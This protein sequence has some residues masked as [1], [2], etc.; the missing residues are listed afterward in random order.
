ML[1]LDDDSVRLVRDSRGA[2][3]IE[4]ALIAALVAIGMLAGVM[5]LGSGNS[6]SW[7]NTT[8][9]LTNAMQGA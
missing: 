3:A 5:A 2:T 9:K 8:A 4:Y 7:G 1:R 6:S